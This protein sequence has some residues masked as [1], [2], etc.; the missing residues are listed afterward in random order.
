MGEWDQI[1]I[2]GGLIE[3]SFYESYELCEL[4][5][6]LWDTIDT[7]VLIPGDCWD[8]P[9]LTYANIKGLERFK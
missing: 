2:K 5:K 6:V 7:I 4:R 8:T 1:K 9:W 3:E